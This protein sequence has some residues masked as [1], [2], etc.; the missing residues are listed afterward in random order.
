VALF[1]RHCIRFGGGKEYRIE[2]KGKFMPVPAL[3][4]RACPSHNKKP[5]KDYYEQS[6]LQGVILR[7]KLSFDL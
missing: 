6:L 1:F 2:I 5:E 3:P 7:A 4:V